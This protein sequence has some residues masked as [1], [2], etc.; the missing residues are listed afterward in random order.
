MGDADTHWR[1]Q[2]DA[3]ALESA[4]QTPEISDVMWR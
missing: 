2:E 4:L 3:A 1:D